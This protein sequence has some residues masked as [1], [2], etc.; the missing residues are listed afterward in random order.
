M[1][2][3]NSAEKVYLGQRLA[4]ARR[5]AGL[6]QKQLSSQAGLPIVTLQK[7]ENGANNLL[8]ARTETTL[9]LSK[10]LGTTVEELVK[11]EPEEE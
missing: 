10:V 2:K 5:E 8:W 1:Q 11:F 9:A 7:L 3:L 6:T 4:S